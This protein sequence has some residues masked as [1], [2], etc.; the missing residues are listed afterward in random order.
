MWPSIPLMVNSGT[1]PAI[2]IAA[3]KKIPRFTSI[4]AL[5]ITANLPRKEFDRRGSALH[6]R[7]DDEPFRRW[8]RQAP[9]NVFHYDNGRIDHQTEVDRPH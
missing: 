2:M 4:A 8:L 6:R 5:P 1:K 7:R 9:D 3:E